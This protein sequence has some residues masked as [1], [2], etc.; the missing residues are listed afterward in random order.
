MSET[1]IIHEQPHL[2]FH[3][4]AP[5]QD[6]GTEAQA[7]WGNRGKQERI[8]FRMGDGSAGGEGVGCRAGGCGKEESVSLH[9]SAIGF[10]LN[11]PALKHSSRTG[12][13]TYD[14]LREVL[15]IEK[16]IDNGKVRMSTAM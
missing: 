12:P 3:D 16:C 2:E 7:P 5:R 4:A 15:S 11:H 13:V 6:D 8:G 9:R 10:E 1:L 14:C